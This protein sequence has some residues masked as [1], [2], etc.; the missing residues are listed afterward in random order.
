M[1]TNR[2]NYNSHSDIK[3]LMRGQRKS[4]TIFNKRRH[5][6]WKYEKENHPRG[7]FRKL[8]ELYYEIWFHEN[9]SLYHVKGN[10]YEIIG[11][12]DPIL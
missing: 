4:M 6:N 8:T 2:D 7:D 10:A 11:A 12:Y 9:L 5:R 3:A 1:G